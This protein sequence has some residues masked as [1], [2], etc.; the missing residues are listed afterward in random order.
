VDI[1]FEQ[2]IKGLFGRNMTE[3]T[4][5]MVADVLA[6]GRSAAS[7][8]TKTSQAGFVYKRPANA[9]RRRGRETTGG[10]FPQKVQW[11]AVDDQ[12]ELNVAELNKDV[13][14]WIIQ[15]IGTGQRANIRTGGQSNPRGRPKKNSQNVVTV[16][17]QLGRRISSQLAFGTSPRGRYSAPGAASGEQIYLRRQLKNVPLNPRAIIIHEEIEGQHFVREGAR[18]GFRQYRPSVLAAARRAFAGHPYRP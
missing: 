7:D 4:N 1:T 17:S 2:N 9:A 10:R 6:A 8:A 5:R 18:E 13:P 16:K 3:R 11:S 14:Y 12:V 15:E